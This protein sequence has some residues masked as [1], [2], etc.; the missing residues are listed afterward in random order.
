[1]DK[2]EKHTESPNPSMLVDFE[3]MLAQS[4][5]DQFLWTA[6]SAVIFTL[7]VIAWP[8]GLGPLDTSADNVWLFARG[9]LPGVLCLGILLVLVAI[10]LRMEAILQRGLN[11]QPTAEIINLTSN[12]RGGDAKRLAAD[13]LW[14]RAAFSKDPQARAFLAGD[15]W[16][17]HPPTPY[18]PNDE[19]AAKRP[20]SR[21]RFYAIVLLASGVSMVA[22][23]LLKTFE[24]AATHGSS[25][26]LSTT[27]ALGL[28][29]MGILSVVAL[30]AYL[31]FDAHLEQQ[32]GKKPIPHLVESWLNGSERAGKALRRR[33]RFHPELHETAERCGWRTTGA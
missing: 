15:D 4:K 30:I 26:R 16:H 17:D 12:L 27:A 1:M 18:I 20:R 22:T 23:F 33:A 8:A 9:L 6:L 25:V 21:V 19:L 31:F 3:S 32:E 14:L 13:L 11:E 2:F 29:T 24:F 28:Q 5:R 10:H 7:I